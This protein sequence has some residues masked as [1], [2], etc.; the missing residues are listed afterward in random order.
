MEK[1]HSLWIKYIYLCIYEE[2]NKINIGEDYKKS[3]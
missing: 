2:R 1:K 3:L